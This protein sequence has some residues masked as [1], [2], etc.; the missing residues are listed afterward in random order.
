M[1]LHA[2]GARLRHG[3]LLGGKGGQAQVALANGWMAEQGI[4]RPERM[5]AAILP[6]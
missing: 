4:K 1:L 6:P 3:R 5:A 2:A